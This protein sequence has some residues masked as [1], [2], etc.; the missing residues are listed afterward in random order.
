MGGEVTG[1]ALA[2]TRVTVEPGR[3]SASACLDWEI[4]VPEGYWEVVLY[5]MV[6][7]SPRSA[8]AFLAVLARMPTSSGTVTSPVVVGGEVD[9]LASL[10]ATVGRV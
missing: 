10:W 5:L 8:S 6:Q 1:G 7:C 9:V 4:T 2:T 3:T